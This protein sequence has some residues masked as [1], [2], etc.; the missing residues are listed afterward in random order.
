MNTVKLDLHIHSVYSDGRYTPAQIVAEAKEQELAVVALTDHDT[1][2]GIPEFLVEAKRLGIPAIYGIEFTCV[3]NGRDIH[4]LGYNFHPTDPGIHQLIDQFI[5]LQSLFTL[6]RISNFEEKWGRTVD[7]E[8]LPLDGNFTPIRLAHWLLETGHITPE[9][10]PQRICDIDP[11][12]A[13]EDQT[14]EL[15]YTPHLPQAEE[16][17]SVI[18]K[19]GGFP[20]LAHPQ[21]MEMTFAE[22]QRLYARGLKGIEAFYPGQDPY[23]YLQ[24]AERLALAVTAGSDYHGV[25]DRNGRSIG[26]TVPEELP[27]NIYLYSGDISVGMDLR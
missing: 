3:L 24:W 14:V 13:P 22:V 4:L 16:V 25:L 15:N 12:F 11:L 5:E 27:A 9:E 20:V 17:V 19:A 21:P 26:M 8:L 7:L 18:A 6:Q 2:D 10:F 23:P 1:L